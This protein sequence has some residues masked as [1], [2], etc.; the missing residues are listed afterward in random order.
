MTV[1][2][3]SAAWKVLNGVKFQCGWE[4][5]EDSFKKLK[6]ELMKGQLKWESSFDADFLGHIISQVVK[7][8][9]LKQRP[10]LRKRVELK[11][12][13]EEKEPNSFRTKS[14]SVTKKPA[15]KKKKK[16]REEEKE[17][18]EIKEKK[19][20]EEKLKEN[21]CDK[22]VLTGVPQRKKQ[23]TLFQKFLPPLIIEKKKEKKNS[24]LK[25]FFPPLKDLYISFNSSIINLYQKINFFLLTP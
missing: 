12:S 21:N 7:E 9:K 19:D 1:C 13:V 25:S 8:L 23:F 6:S 3:I 14:L 20:E 24:N 17:K 16:N 10:R 5:T 18:E 15:K 22:G 11:E 2:N 4:R